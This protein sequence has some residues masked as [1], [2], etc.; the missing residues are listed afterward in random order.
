[1]KT[2]HLKYFAEEMKY[3]APNKRH[4]KK[5]FI[6]AHRLKEFRDFKSSLILV[7]EI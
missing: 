2:Y 5:T 3:I 7:K 4:A 6:T 1:M